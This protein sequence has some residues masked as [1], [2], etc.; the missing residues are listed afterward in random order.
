MV[1]MWFKFLFCKLVLSVM[2]LGINVPF[3]RYCLL[4]DTR[5]SRMM[6]T[7]EIDIVLMGPCVVLIGRL[8]QKAV[9]PSLLWFP[10]HFLISS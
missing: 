1:C 10:I 2:I 6:L 7:V 4:E 5:P 3:K 9:G 8:L